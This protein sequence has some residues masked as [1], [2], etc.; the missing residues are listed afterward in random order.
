M[1]EGGHRMKEYHLQG[2]H[3][4]NCAK[5]LEAQ[6]QKLPHGDKS[7]LNFSTATLHLPEEVDIRAAKKILNADKVMM[8]AKPKTVHEPQH[9]H[10]HH[11]HVTDSEKA[12]GKMKIVFLL[13]LVFAAGEIVF[14]ILFNSAAILSDAVHDFGDAMSIGL[15][16]AFQKISTKE[17]N[18][19]YSFGH[20]RF[21][22]LGALST[23]I[24]LIVGS[25]LMIFRSV[26]LLFNPEPVHS[27][28]M[29]W[30]A[31][32]AIAINGF[33][34]W[35]LSS[36]A[37]ANEKV[38]TLHL[39]EDVLGWVGVLIVSI[40]LRFQDWY[41]LD[42]LLSIVIAGFILSQAIPSFFKIANIFLE[43]VPEEV[44]IK[45]IEQAIYDIKDVHGVS[46]LHI[47]S[48]DGQENAF[49]VTVYVSTEDVKQFEDIRESIRMLLK[50]NN[51]THS[52]IEIV[53][54]LE[55]LIH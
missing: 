2:V 7:R 49:A 13:N 9:S 33:A 11:H 14:G 42:P 3:C 38:L 26:P 39:L 19:K 34:T 54:D 4:A 30:V 21:S 23:S 29:L 40:I 47:W 6:L 10:G 8:N 28:G 45:Q 43:S 50:E 35:L 1:I 53:S 37:S 17:A 32:A 24:V 16:W 18:E 51:V 22:L 41:F 27:Q 55:R 52:T 48:I 5:R 46:H 15:A 20:R 36:G 31:I 25:T 44:D 12:S